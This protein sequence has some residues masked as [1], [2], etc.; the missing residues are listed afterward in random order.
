MEA[1][2]LFPACFS[3]EPRGS[4]PGGRCGWWAGVEVG[5]GETR[6]MVRPRAWQVHQGD[7]ADP[8]AQPVVSA[9]CS[10]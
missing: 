7:F 5:W 1:Q 2:V 10:Q 8:H 6:S 4:S 9:V 3:S